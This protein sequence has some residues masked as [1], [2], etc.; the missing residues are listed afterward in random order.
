MHRVSAEYHSQWFTVW[1]EAQV[2]HWW[3]CGSWVPHKKETHMGCVCVCASTGMHTHTVVFGQ[4]WRRSQ[5][6]GR[7]RVPKAYYTTPSMNYDLSSLGHLA[8]IQRQ[9]WS[10][11]YEPGSE[12]DA[13]FTEAKDIPALP[14]CS[15]T[16]DWWQTL[17]W[18]CIRARSLFQARHEGFLPVLPPPP[19]LPPHKEM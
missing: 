17:C 12:L 7:I 13:K 11:C 8:L 5:S 10:P 6:W 19:A 1:Q 2:T 9:V 3:F 15:F 4:R 14:G 18:W 16:P